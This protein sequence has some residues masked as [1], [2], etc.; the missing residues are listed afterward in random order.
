MVISCI[1]WLRTGVQWT[2]YSEYIRLFRRVSQCIV[3]IVCGQKWHCC[4]SVKDLS[5]LKLMG[6]CTDLSHNS[7]LAVQNLATQ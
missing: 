2:S 7:G 1:Y 5:G 3:D 6:V 4:P